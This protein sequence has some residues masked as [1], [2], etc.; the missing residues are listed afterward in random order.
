MFLLA[1]NVAFISRIALL[2]TVASII[3]RRRGY[4]T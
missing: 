1:Y 2:R 4:K 3:T